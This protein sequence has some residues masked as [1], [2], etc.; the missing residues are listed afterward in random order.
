MPL[1]VVDVQPYFKY[2]GEECFL[3]AVEKEIVR[4]VND[5]LPVIIV[6]FI[7]FGETYERLTRHLKGY[8][9][10]KR[11]EKNRRDGSAEVL[12]ACR[13]AGF[14][15]AFFRVCGLYTFE[16][17]AE[18]VEG[19]AQKAPGCRIHVVKQALIDKVA[20]WK[21][22][23]EVA[24]ASLVSQNPGEPMDTLGADRTGGMWGP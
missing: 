11:V 3:A 6:E 23:P 16:C 19:L 18:T 2:S 22:F 7:G 15:T 4:A 5:G 12:E 21:M 14:G 10:F 24:N 9:R 1:V 8:P 17:V 20:G 13:E